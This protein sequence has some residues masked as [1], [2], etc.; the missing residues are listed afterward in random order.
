[1]SLIMNGTNDSPSAEVFTLRGPKDDQS[2]KE[3]SGVKRPP[4][5]Q[6]MPNMIGYLRVWRPCH[7]SSVIENLVKMVPFARDVVNLHV[8]H[9]N[10]TLCMTD[11]HFKTRPGIHSKQNKHSGRTHGSE[12]FYINHEHY[13]C[14]KEGGIEQTHHLYKGRP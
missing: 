11:L 7:R 1:M 4:H 10:G 14:Q 5:A 8:L 3:A 13:H 2:T 9:V 6:F 12:P